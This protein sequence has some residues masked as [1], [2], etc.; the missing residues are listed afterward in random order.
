MVGTLDYA[1]ALLESVDT[2]QPPPALLQCLLEQL[3]RGQRLFLYG[4]F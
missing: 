1:V 2:E 3:G 4:T